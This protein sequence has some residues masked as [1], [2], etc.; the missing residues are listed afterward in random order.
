MEEYLN[1][2]KLI[3]DQLALASSPNDDEDLVLLILNGLPKE[4]NALKTTIRARSKLISLDQL[5]ALLSSESI[6]VESTLKHTHASKIPG[7]LPY[8]AQR[9]NYSHRGGPR[10]C[11]RGRGAFKGR[12]WG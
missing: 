8:T 7:S 5:S 9:S 1:Q 12:E 6:R 2:F 3:S 4:Y 10:G 11:N